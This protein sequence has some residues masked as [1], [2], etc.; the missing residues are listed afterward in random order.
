MVMLKIDFTNAFNCINRA[1][2]LDLLHGSEQFGGLYRWISACYGVSSSLLF[3]Q[4]VIESLAGVQQGDPLGPLLF[5]LVLQTLT[6]KIKE[7][8]PAL[9][10]NVWF[11]DDG[12]L[13]GRTDDVLRAVQI[14][15]EDGPLLGVRINPPKCKLWWPTIP[16]VFVFLTISSSAWILQEWRC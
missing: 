16:R 12:T 4:H 7:A 6:Q 13:I 8:C 9:A 2:F 11:L 15:S 14:I 10:L 1:A 3:G 5:S